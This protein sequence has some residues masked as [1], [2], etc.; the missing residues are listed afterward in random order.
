M[1]SKNDAIWERK[2]RRN[3]C[4]TKLHAPATPSS[5]IPHDCSS[6]EIDARRRRSI[7]LNASTTLTANKPP[8]ILTIR[9]S[10]ASA[11]Y[12]LLISL[13]T[14]LRYQSQ[15]QSLRRTIEFISTIPHHTSTGPELGAARTKAI[16][17]PPPGGSH[18]DPGLEHSAQVAIALK[19]MKRSS[20][21]RS[22]TNEAFHRRG[23]L[24]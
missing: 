12:P 13:H 19:K 18:I 2:N 10:V 23:G 22:N 21:N 5:P 14:G 3:P 1:P 4:S 17:L 11:T 6:S 16:C 9:I 7:R 20:E 24:H 8:R 15:D